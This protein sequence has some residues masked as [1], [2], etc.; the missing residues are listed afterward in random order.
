MTSQIFTDASESPC[1]L[2]MDE[3]SEG[4]VQLQIEK[5]ETV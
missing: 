4:T 1:I 5:A 3:T 2:R